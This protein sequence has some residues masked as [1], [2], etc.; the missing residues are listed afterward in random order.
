MCA[1]AE[2]VRSHSGYLFADLAETYTIFYLGWLQE[3]QFDEGPQLNPGIKKCSL[4]RDKYFREDSRIRYLR[5]KS[6]NM[7]GE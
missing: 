2:A 7:R 1:G 6:L 5:S 4:L 3:S